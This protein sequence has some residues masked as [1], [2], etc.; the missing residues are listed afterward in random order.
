VYIAIETPVHFD[1]CPAHATSTARRYTVGP[2]DY[3]GA[4]CGRVA[5]RI[6]D[7]KFSLDGADYTLL[8]NNG[9]V[10]RCPPPRLLAILLLPM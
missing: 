9:Q 4:T 2:N 8:V 1:T 10:Q 3:K 6:A 5:N 7:G